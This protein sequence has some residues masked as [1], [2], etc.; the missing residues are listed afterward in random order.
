MTEDFDPT[1][2]DHPEEALAVYAQLRERCPVAHSAAYGGFW[3]LTRHA[4]VAAAASD[5]RTFISSVRAVVPSDPRGLRRPPLNY[6]APAHTPYRRALDRTLQRSRID[7]LAPRL[8][9]HA[10]RELAPMLAR[11][12]G[13]VAQEFGARFPAWVTTEWL[14]LSPATAP[15][16]ADTA[17]RWVQ[18]WRRMDGPVVN[19][20]SEAMYDMARALVAARREQPLPVEEDPASSLLAERHEGAPLE[21][22]QLVG[23]LRQSLVVGMVA[24]PILL[25]SVC[26]HLA[27]DRE[28]QDRLRADPSLVPAAVEEFLRLYTPY[29]GFARTVA[30]DVDLHGRRISPGEPVTLVYAAANRDPAVF[31]D[32]DAFVLDRPNIAA[33]LAFGRGR[34]HCAGMPL[35]R[36]ALAVALETLLAAT[37]GFVLDGP[38]E[39]ARMPEIGYVSVPLRFTPH[40]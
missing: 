16:L 34:H 27:R 11:G 9:E 35:A 25:G 37:A 36:L 19:A 15:V 1:A 29:R 12:S 18:A 26:V 30:H 33:H 3:A 17:T 22:E 7:R 21:E 13:D 39:G 8:R 4:D 20:A 38:L 6:D 2:T 28:L 23:A 32:P 24:P 14:N 40:P 31:P 5:P 10:A